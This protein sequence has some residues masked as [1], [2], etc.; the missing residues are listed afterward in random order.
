M[1]NQALG[2]CSLAEFAYALSNM[3]AKTVAY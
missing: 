1:G 2:T 3:S